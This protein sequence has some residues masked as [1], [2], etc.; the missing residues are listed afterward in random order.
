MTSSYSAVNL[1]ALPFPDIIEELDYEAILSAMIT[2]LQT[3]DTAFTALVESDPAYKILEVCAYRETILRQRIND[4]AKGV[5]LAYATG[6]DLDHIGA[7]FN[8]PRLLVTAANNAAIPPVPAVY[9]SDTDFRRRIQL[10]FERMTTAGSEG[11][12]IFH[13]LKVS[14]TIRDV[15]IKSPEA[16][17][18]LVTLQCYNATNGG[19][20]GVGLIG[21]VLRALNAEDIRP[22]TDEVAVQSTTKD[23]YTIVAELEI[24]LLGSDAEIVR[25]NAENALRA[26]VYGKNTIGKDIP[27]SAIYAALHQPEVE[28]VILTT[29]SS[30]VIVADTHFAYA[31]SITVTIAEPEEE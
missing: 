21:A 15:A 20:A 11:S 28:R 4:A 22:L 10:S 23:N 30:D 1:A 27:L 31:T 26:Y 19:L 18:V 12:Y 25:Q 3:R 16:G 9:E 14:G 2:D 17:K 8:L 13:A 24:P 7:N 6:A 5:T 29:P